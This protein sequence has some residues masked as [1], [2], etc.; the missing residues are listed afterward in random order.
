VREREAVAA[1]ELDPDQQVP[2]T[3]IRPV[4]DEL[5]R[6]LEA[7]ARGRELER[8]GVGAAARPHDEHVVELP[9][10][11]AHDRGRAPRD[12]PLLERLHRA[13]SW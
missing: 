5:H 2:G 1:R 6:L 10:V 13:L 8:L 4:T 3:A 9:R 7:H 12:L 11:D